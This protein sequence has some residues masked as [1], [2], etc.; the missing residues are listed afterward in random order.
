MAQ[1][2][3][4]SRFIALSTAAEAFDVS[5]KT[6]RRRIDDGTL[7]GYK[8]GGLT[9]VREDDLDRLIRPIRVSAPTGRT[10]E[11]AHRQP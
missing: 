10:A 9:R 2:T 7:P 8:I 5:T 1:T 11:R 3:G 6:L 4:R